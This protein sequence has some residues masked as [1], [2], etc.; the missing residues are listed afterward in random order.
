MKTAANIGRNPHMMDVMKRK[1][2]WKEAGARTSSAGTGEKH[3]RE[4][5]APE[6]HD[7]KIGATV[8]RHD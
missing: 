4:L 6:D 5:G 2:A 3:S 8:G 7:S 1:P